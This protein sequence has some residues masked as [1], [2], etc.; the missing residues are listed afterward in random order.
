M[1]LFRKFLLFLVPFLIV[2]CQSPNQP[3][4]TSTP[5]EQDSI[6][7]VYHASN[8]PLD[9]FQS[10]KVNKKIRIY[11]SKFPV[12]NRS[13]INQVQNIVDEKG[14][15]YIRL[16]LTADGVAA[17][18]KTPQNLGYVTVVKGNLVSIDAFVQQSNLFVL[19]PDQE[20][21][22]SLSKIISSSTN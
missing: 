10:L 7:E 18:S 1:N 15:A 11:V 2:A 6:V 19:V 9:G 14:N 4:D 20:T 17:L 5:T 8:E 22:S 16:G 12:I 21:A 13:Y 3:G